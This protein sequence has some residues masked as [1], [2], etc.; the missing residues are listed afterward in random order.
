MLIHGDMF[1]NI[2]FSTVAFKSKNE[3]P[4][5]IIGDNKFYPRIL[6]STVSCV[7]NGLRH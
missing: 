4:R 2:I 7:G 3:Y 6:I 1:S 5:K